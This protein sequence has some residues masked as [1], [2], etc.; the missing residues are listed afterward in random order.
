MPCRNAIESFVLKSK[1]EPSLGKDDICNDSVFNLI[2]ASSIETLGFSFKCDG[3]NLTCGVKK[4]II[5]NEPAD[6]EL[7]MHNPPFCCREP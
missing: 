3:A 2:P 1:A 4:K 7:V 6:R 5:K